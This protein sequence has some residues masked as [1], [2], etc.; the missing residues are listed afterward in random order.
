MAAQQAERH[1]RGRNGEVIAQA[2]V[3]GKATK[4]KAPFD[5]ID[6]SAGYAYEV[7][8]MTGWGKD[9]KIHISDASMARKQTWAKEYGLNMVL[10]AVVVYGPETVEVYQ[11]ELKQS[12]RV[13]QLTL[14]T[15]KEE[16]TKI[17]ASMRGYWQHQS[18]GG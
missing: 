16:D 17:A 14:I 1:E 7:K 13:H 15:P 5:L 12:I 10:I 6:F 8:T 4:H 18:E 9:N 11:G 2:V 3:G